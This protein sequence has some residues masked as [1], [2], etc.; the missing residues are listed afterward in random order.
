M[1]PCRIKYS[2]AYTYDELN[3]LKTVVQAEGTPHEAV[4]EYEYDAHDNLTMVKDAEGKVTRYAY[5]DFGRVT[6]IIS[7]DTGSTQYTYDEAGNVKTKTDAKGVTVSYEYDALNRLTRIDIPEEPDIIYSYDEA[8][9][10]NGAGRMTTVTDASGTTRYD[11]DERGSVVEQRATI[12]GVLYI[13]RYEYN[14]NNALTKITYPQGAQ[15]AYQRNA[16]GNIV[17]VDAEW[18]AGS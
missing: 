8:D 2:T 3:R 16:A 5:D 11:Y 18:R 13:T 10:Q 15:V 4:T 1:R 12:G 17:S 6:E 7:P 9:V 14:R